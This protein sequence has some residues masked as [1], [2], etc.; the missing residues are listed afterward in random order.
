MVQLVAR[1]GEEPSRDPALLK[2]AEDCLRE[3]RLTKP[4]WVEWKRDSS[5][6]AD[7]IFVTLENGEGSTARLC[8]S[9]DKLYFYR[10]DASLSPEYRILGDFDPEQLRSLA[11]AGRNP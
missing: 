7:G 9:E 5:F 2:A 8:V 4:L 1:G 3:L 6:S 10:E 11:E